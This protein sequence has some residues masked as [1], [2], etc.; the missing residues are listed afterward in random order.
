M[1]RLTHPFNMEMLNIE[2]IDADNQQAEERQS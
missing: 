2:A 1:S